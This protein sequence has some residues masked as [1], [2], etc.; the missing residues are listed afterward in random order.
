MT[1][2]QPEPKSEAPSATG[3]TTTAR[4]TP[5]AWVK[6]AAEKMP[7]KW[8]TVAALGLFLAAT[9]AFGGLAD[10]PAA[11]E[12]P[13]AQLEPGD[14]HDTGQLKITL[15]RAVL[16]DELSGSGTVPIKDGHERVLVVT[17][18]IENPGDTVLYSSS[19]ATKQLEI[20]GLPEKRPN[21]DDVEA[22]V[23]RL[24]DA[25]LSPLIQP[26][27]AVE[28]AFTW[29][30]PDDLLQAGDDLHVTISDLTWFEPSFLMQQPAVWTTPAIPAAELDLEVEDVGA[31]VDA[32]DAG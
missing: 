30:V 24:D 6:V 32:E 5:A 18:T 27:L 26:G 11:A 9:A 10:A 1:D 7:A 31:G 15:D 25:T 8:V 29:P 28:V 17:G 21:E 16:I 4:R 12:K 3:P 19:F 20:E 2:P 14:T 13:L 23:A 22:S